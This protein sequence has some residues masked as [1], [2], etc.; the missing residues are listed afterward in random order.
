M[1]FVDKIRNVVIEALADL[2]LDE[3]DPASIEETTLFRDASHR[4]RRFRFETVRAVW[5]SD[6]RQIE[7]F[8]EDG[9]FLK[10]VALAAA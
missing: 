3:A 1:V 7:F 5:F 9:R 4:G 2:G 8:S 10:S 6:T